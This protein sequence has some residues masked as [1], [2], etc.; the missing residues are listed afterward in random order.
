M[1]YSKKNRYQR[2]INI[3]NWVLKLK[4]QYPDITTQEIYEQYIKPTYQI[5]RRTFTTYLDTNA[6]KL[7]KDLEAKTQALD[8]KY[9][10]LSMTFE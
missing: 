10:Q 9:E 6:K 8:S 3:Q 2:I 1:A 7:I 5:S 4:E